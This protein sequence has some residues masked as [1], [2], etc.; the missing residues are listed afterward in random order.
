MFCL[1]RR[2]DKQA[3]R[4]RRPSRAEQSNGVGGR[5]SATGSRVGFGLSLLRAC[6]PTGRSDQSPVRLV[7]V[8]SALAHCGRAHSALQFARSNR[9]APTSR[10][11]APSTARFFML[12]MRARLGPANDLR[13]QS[14]VRARC[15]Q[16]VAAAF[17]S[18]DF[19]CDG[20]RSNRVKSGEKSARGR[21]SEPAKRPSD[22]ATERPSQPTDRS[23]D[24]LMGA[25]GRLF[26]PRASWPTHNGTGKLGQLSTRPQ[27][28]VRP[29]VPRNSRF[30]R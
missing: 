24:R 25:V 6:K 26:C 11:A 3:A 22:R 30:N 18:M 2:A 21:R 17:R 7:G 27:A 5:N 15:Q 10:P 19:G 29:I 8:D 14:K 20:T 16:V 9:L 12:H 13:A 23:M 1:N 28:W 4:N